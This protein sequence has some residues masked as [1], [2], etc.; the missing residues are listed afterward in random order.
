M[1]IIKGHKL[2]K[3]LTLL[4]LALSLLI[5]AG[6]V[7]LRFRALNRV[8]EDALRG[9]GADSVLVGDVSVT[10]FRGV[11]VGGLRAHKRISADED[12]TVAVS[13]ADVSCNLFALA[14]AV[15]VNPRL[16]NPERDMFREAYEKPLEL[17][18]GLCARLMSL[19]SFKRA[20]VSGAGIWF[21]GKGAPGLSA[22]GVSAGVVRRGGRR[23]SL[24]GDI[25]A[26]LA[27]V[28]YLANVENFSVKLRAG[29]GRLDFTDGNGA[30]FGGR[31]SAGLSLSLGDSRLIDGSASVRGL[32]LEKFCAGTGFSPGAL[33]GIVNLD[34]ALEPGSA[35]LDSIRASGS[36]SVGRL[37]AVEIALQ[38]TAAVN[39]VSRDL[40]SLRFSEVRGDFQLSGG[41]LRFG[42]ITGVGEVLS[43]RAAGWVGFDGKLDYSLDGEFSKK[44]VATLPKLVRNSLEETESGG[45]GFK[46]RISGTF[47]RPRVDIDKSVYDRAIGGFFRNL[48]K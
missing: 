37:T 39:Q 3:L 8:V 2:E 21:T 19:R 5:L 6:F 29:D 27:V 44:F 17:A 35:A 47:H 38:K 34:A 7:P 36:V 16:F 46:C 14:A 13:R 42:K 41:K 10:L 40:R 11:R 33:T 31:V 22:E 43:F 25:S 1:P 45:G 15:A 4:L 23:S 24:D 48:F 20:A 26:A 28:P 12:Y 9:A 18:G 32:D 30:L